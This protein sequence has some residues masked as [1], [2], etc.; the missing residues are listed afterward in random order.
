MSSRSPWSSPMERLEEAA[1]AYAEAEAD[2][3]HERAKMRLRR[4][5]VEF[6]D[7]NR[8]ARGPARGTKYR[9]RAA[10]GDR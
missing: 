6:R 7:A 9:P 10:G 5:A 4:A 8:G 3:D 1:L 2:E